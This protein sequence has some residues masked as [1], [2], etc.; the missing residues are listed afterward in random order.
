MQYTLIKGAGIDNKQLSA[1]MVGQYDT[2]QPLEVDMTMYGGSGLDLSVKKRFISDV[3]MIPHTNPIFTWNSTGY[4]YPILR[5]TDPSTLSS[6]Q[7]HSV[8]LFKLIHVKFNQMISFYRILRVGTDR[9]SLTPLHKMDEL[10]MLVKEVPQQIRSGD[11]DSV[12]IFLNTYLNCMSHIINVWATTG[13]LCLECSTRSGNVCI[14]L[15]DIFDEIDDY[16][17]KRNAIAN[18][19]THCLLEVFRET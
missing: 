5:P 3:E 18:I 8:D 11:T 14:E 12:E 2:A 15:K 16:I 13:S 4:E 17:F 9:D 7:Y 10:G 6:I 1:V 19:P